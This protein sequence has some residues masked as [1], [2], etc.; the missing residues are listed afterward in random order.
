[1]GEEVGYYS[2][3]YKISRGLIQK[4]GEK[5]IIDTP[6]TEAGFTGIG[7]GAAAQGLRPIVEFMVGGA[8]SKREGGG[9]VEYSMYYG[10]GWLPVF[11]VF[12]F[13]FCSTLANTSRKRLRPD[14]T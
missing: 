5:R 13:F 11:C 8:L 3:A 10:G 1:M 2:G 4:Y 14:T 7:V 12:F 9:H 6:I